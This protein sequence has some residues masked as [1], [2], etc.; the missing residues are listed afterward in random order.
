[1]RMVLARTVLASTVRSRTGSTS[2]QV[3][4]KIWF[5]VLARIASFAMN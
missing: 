3:K 2:I 4:S 1:M 5:G